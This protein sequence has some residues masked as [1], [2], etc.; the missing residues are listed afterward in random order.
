MIVIQKPGPPTG[1]AE[2]AGGLNKQANWWDK[3]LIF[4]DYVYVCAV[5]V[6]VYS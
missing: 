6:C 2:I 3:C 1:A 5:Y 4:R